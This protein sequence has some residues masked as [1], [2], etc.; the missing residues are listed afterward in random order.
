[1][2]GDLRAW[3]RRSILASAFVALG[4]SASAQVTTG[5]YDGNGSAG[6]S[7]TVGFRPIFVFI[8]VDYENIA[9]NDLSSGVIRTAMMT[10]DNAK[11]LTGTQALMS[12]L[13]TSL[14]A[15]GFTVGDDLR[16]NAAGASCGGTCTY[17]WT[18]FGADPDFAMGS[19][20]GNGTSVGDP[21]SITGLGFSPEYV[22]VLP[23]TTRR[24]G[25][26]TTAG[27][28]FSRRMSPNGSALTDAIT[29]MDAD[30]F[31]VTVSSSA[32]DNP[33]ENSQTYYYAAWN[34]APGKMVIGEYLGNGV[35]N[36]QIVGMSFSPSWLILSAYD[37]GKDPIHR[38]K[39][40][41]TDAGSSFRKDVQTGYVRA[42]LP[43]GFQIG[44]NNVV[45][46]AGFNFFWVA[47]GD[48]AACPPMTVSESG[49]TI[50]TTT[51]GSFELRF[52]SS[53]GG[54]IDQWYELNRDPD[55]ST[56][57]MNNTGANNEY[58]LNDFALYNAPTTYQLNAETAAA[59]DLL[60][61]TPLRTLVRAEG[62]LGNVA[63]FDYRQNTTVYSSGKL[64]NRMQFTNNTG[65]PLST[66]QVNWY[67][68]R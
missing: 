13:I 63:G 39:D 48:Q 24:A 27:G 51:A 42:L 17:Y 66:Y 26:R 4:G 1:M 61:V 5:T 18:V 16:V 22:M 62:E 50:T 31:T 41:P 53:A 54:S 46:E 11:P 9:D 47:F 14:D 65:G 6:R 49:G 8:K 44:S 43:N 32:G 68:W 23:A 59:L 37:D 58:A 20:T 45:N 25:H 7:I 38:T 40:I 34:A 64:Y 35:N 15:N 36:R 67:S 2:G 56:N 12:G 29:S 21:Q 19:Y 33:N 28:T 3:A 55:R 60:E 10:G 52:N 57:L 30:G